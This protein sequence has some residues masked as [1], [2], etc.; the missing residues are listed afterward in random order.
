MKLAASMFLLAFLLAPVT[1]QCVDAEKLQNE[2]EALKRLVAEKSAELEKL[3]Q[4][5][6]QLEEA[7]QSLQKKQQESDKVVRKFSGLTVGGYI[8]MRYR[9]DT[10]LPVDATKVADGSARENF[11]ISRAR[12]DIRWTPHPKVFCSLAC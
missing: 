2:I 3:Q 1:P 10:S 9:R 8:Q 6:K 12:L 7:L 5:L 4:Q 11:W